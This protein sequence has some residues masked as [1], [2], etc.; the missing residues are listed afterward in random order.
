MEAGFD[1]SKTISWKALRE[2]E[3][4]TNRDFIE[5]LQTFIDSEK[6]K[7][8]R[9]KA[10]FA[11]GHIAKNVDD[12]NT[13]Q[14]F[15]NRLDKETDKYVIASML[16]VLAKI[17]KPKGTDLT[18]L[19]AATKDDR[20]QVRQKAIQAFASCDEE[21]AETILIEF[22]DTSDDPYD[23]IYSNATLNK[24]GTPKAIPFLEKHLKSRK[25]D[26]KFSAQSAIDEIK[27]RHHLV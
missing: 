12:K 11:L 10:Y 6:D 25:R 27:K 18:L 21:I 7:E 5:Q 15:I 2:A 14:F 22:V 17:S 4:I 23:L 8:K 3:K 13:S 1:S 16:T 9:D 24:I 19:I 20:W 26:V